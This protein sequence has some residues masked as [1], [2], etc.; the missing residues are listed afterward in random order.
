MMM[1]LTAISVLNSDICIYYYL[2]IIVI[3]NVFFIIDFKLTFVFVFLLLVPQV[4]WTDFL[5]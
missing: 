3:M 2:G 4:I 1:M 5:P